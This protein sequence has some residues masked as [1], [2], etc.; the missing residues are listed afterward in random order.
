[1][2]VSSG[3]PVSE[4]SLLMRGPGNSETS[5]TLEPSAR[6]LSGAVSLGAEVKADAS[7][8]ERIMGKRVNVPFWAKVS[9]SG[10]WIVVCTLLEVGKENV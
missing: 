2:N 4:A 6:G 10:I 9:F 8:M 5:V 1:M 7:L 3:K